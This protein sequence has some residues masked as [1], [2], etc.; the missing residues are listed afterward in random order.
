MTKKIYDDEIARLTGKVNEYKKKIKEL[1]RAW[2]IE[3]LEYNGYHIGQRITVNGQEYEIADVDTDSSVLWVLGYRI[4]KNGEASNV[5]T[6][7]YRFPL[8]RLPE[9]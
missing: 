3:I 1:R 8:L 5:L 4:K 7:L 6:T 9:E 2:F